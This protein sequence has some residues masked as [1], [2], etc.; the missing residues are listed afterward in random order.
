MSPLRIHAVQ[1][2][3]VGLLFAFGHQPRLAE[4]TLGDVAVISVPSSLKGPV[5][6]H[7]REGS[8]GWLAWRFSS[9]YLWASMSGVTKYK[10]QLLVGVMEPTATDAEYDALSYEFNVSYEQRKKIREGPLHTGSITVWEGVYALGA[11]REKSYEYRYV[12][13]AK[14][15]QLVWH[16]VAK[17]AD[18]NLALAQ[19]PRIVSSFRIVR[20]PA[21]RY[22]AMRDAPRKDADNRAG[23]RATVQ[24]M[25]RREGYTALEPG[26]PVLRNGVYFEWMD[27]PEPRYQLLVPLGRVRAAA[28]GSVV[29]RP[30]PLRA[31]TEG[32]AGTV[33]WR[34][35]ADGEWEF[36][37]NVNAYLPLP[38]IGAALAAAQQDKGYVYFYYVGT[39]RVEEENDSARLTS[40]QWFL[41]SIPEVQRRWREGTLVGPGKPEQP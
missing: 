23:K 17:E 32:L 28:S 25:L 11:D 10:Q 41:G 16:G 8:M 19:I 27:D 5:E 39:V 3:S 36:M 35:I 18:V 40:L 34:E 13:R 7:G 9:T 12:D 29:N 6:V 21:A 31:S 1:L 24:A 20:E 4:R 22:A 26:K 2:A 14:R 33:G 30:R 37:N 15:L 38:G